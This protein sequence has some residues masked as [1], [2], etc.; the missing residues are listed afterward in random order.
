MKCTLTLIASLLL[1]PV[2]VSAQDA[3][4]HSP[5]TTEQHDAHMDWW[6]EAKFGM[7]IHWGLYAIPARGEWVM[8][9]EKIPVAEYAKLAT[10]F[11]PVKFNATEWV[12]FAKDAG[13]KYI[14]ITAKHHDGF[15][16]YGSKVSPYN[17]VDATPF[18][19][20]PMKELAAA[21]AKEGIK[22]G[23]YY[24]QAQDWH[25]P[26]GAVAR[27]SWDP[28][29]KGDF[30]HYLHT[31]AIPQVKELLS[32]YNPAVI[33]FDTPVNMTAASAREVLQVVRSIR[34]ETVVNSRILY[35]GAK[36]EGLGKAELDELRD[37]GADYLT[38]R[39]R[40]IPT[41]PAWRDWETCMTLN[42][43][44]GYNEKDHNW[45]SPHTV[46]QMLARVVNKSGNF[47]LNFGPTAEGEL[48]AESVGIMKQV[49]AWLRVNGEAIYGAGPN[50]LKGTRVPTA[51][52]PEDLGTKEASNAKARKSRPARKP[53]TEFDWLATSRPAAKETGQPA[54]IYLHIFKWPAD[55]LAVKG[56]TSQVSKAY[57]LNDAKRAPLKFSQ[58]DGT[59]SV[60]LSGHAPSPI[61][62]VVCLECAAE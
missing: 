44:W 13:M 29:Q 45:K 53:E 54:K 50:D 28:A 31:I 34:P 52:S 40:E 18:K 27:G 38:Y 8:N 23:F 17:I 43:A 59:L 14:V 48:P 10:R 49:G 11:N 9:R 47:L 3:S 58:Q 60:E 37:L 25:H 15:A 41:N 33:W 21:C 42:G 22:L 55:R 51:A 32:G 57:L 2:G 1:T 16:M 20:D 4:P 12:R 19:R 5:K 46:V 7:F 39:D 36:I 26:G 35:S 30:D 56:M 62:T 6:R 61:A 24:S